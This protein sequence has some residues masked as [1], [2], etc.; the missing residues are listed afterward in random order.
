MRFAPFG[1]PLV[2]VAVG[3]GAAYDQQE[4]LR[5]WMRYAPLLPWVIDDGKMVQQRPKTRFLRGEDN[6]NAHGGGSES[7]PP[8]GIRLL[9]T[10]KPPLTRVQGPGVALRAIALRQR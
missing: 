8:N 4:N 7:R 10:P 3:N 5:Q 9:A 1:D 2:I 6:G